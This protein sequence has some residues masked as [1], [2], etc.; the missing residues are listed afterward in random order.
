MK[1]KSINEAYAIV[2]VYEYGSVEQ[3]LYL[4]AASYALKYFEAKYGKD[5]YRFRELFAHMQGDDWESTFVVRCLLHSESIGCPH[6]SIEECDKQNTG[7]YSV[8]K[9]KKCQ[10]CTYL[11]GVEDKWKEK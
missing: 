8:L 10:H 9:G 1:F 7:V 5:D 3:S 6:S 2:E 11:E 4:E